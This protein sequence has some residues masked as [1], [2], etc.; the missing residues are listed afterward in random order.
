MYTDWNKIV[1]S[2]YINI[3]SIFQKKNAFPLLKCVN[4]GIIQQFI[5]NDQNCIFFVDLGRIECLIY[6]KYSRN[7]KF[8]DYNY[9]KES[10]IFGYENV[11]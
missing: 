2:T 1:E 6:K 9:K 10:V 7:E 4:H 3:F 11:G 5:F 8:S